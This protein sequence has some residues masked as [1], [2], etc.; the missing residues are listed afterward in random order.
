[1]RRKRFLWCWPAPPRWWRERKQK[2]L[3]SAFRFRLR[4]SDCWCCWRSAIAKQFIAYPSGG[5][6]YI[7][8]RDN[9]GEMPAQIAGAALLTDYI[10]TVAVSVSSGLEQVASLIPALQPYRVV[11]SLAAI[12]FMTVMNLRGVKESGSFFAGS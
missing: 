8:A 12:S 7:V 6:A 2:C 10:L 11:L 1:M 3:R 5:G 9:L 4:L